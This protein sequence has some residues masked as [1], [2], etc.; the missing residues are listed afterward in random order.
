MPKRRDA[1]PPAG[2]HG[3]ARRR[4]DAQQRQRGAP[5]DIVEHGM[6]R[7]GG[8]DRQR[9]AGARQPADLDD[10]HVGQ[11]RAIAGT[12]QRQSPGS[13]SM[14]LMRIDGAVPL[15]WRSR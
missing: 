14:L 6:W 4:H 1:G 8:D 10:Q 3:V 5:L 12:H 7:V 13:T 9:R 11:R 15:P 2:L